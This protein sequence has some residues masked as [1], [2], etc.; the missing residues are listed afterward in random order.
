[1]ENIKC[2]IESI[3]FQN[4]NNSFSVLNVAIDGEVSTRK[5]VG[6]TFENIQPGMTIEA[7]GDW[8][9]GKYGRQFKVL[10]WQEALPTSLEGMEKYLGS[11]LITGV[12]PKFA[13]KII[14]R[15]GQQSFDIIENDIERLREIPGI[16][17]KCIDS[18]RDSWAKQTGI[19]DVM[20]F[21]QKLGVSSGIATRVYQAYGT[22]SITKVKTNPY[23]LVEDIT[24][25]GFKVAD[26][27]A[28]K[29]GVS[30][31]DPKRCRCG[32]LYEMKQT[33]SAGN[34]Y[35]NEGELFT[36]AVGLLE[37][38][39]KDVGLVLYDMINTKELI[40]DGNALYLP[41]YYYSE[42]G[43]ASRLKALNSQQVSS[44]KIDV[45][46]IL[47]R[48][49]I[50]Y[51]K[52]QEKAIN[53]AIHNNVM[54]MTGGP[55]TGKSVTT[56]GITS[57]FKALGMKILLAAP[58]GR[59]A[60]RLSQVTGMEAKTIHR[61]LEIG[62]D[63]HFTRNENNLL[64]GD[65]LIIDEASMVDILL[66]HSLLKAVPNKMRL[67]LVGDIDQ[68]PSVGAGTVLQDIIESGQFPV[69]RLTNIFR[70]AQG[71]S[72]ITNAY[73]VN[74]GKMPNLTN[75]NSSDFLFY[76]YSTDLCAMNKV[77]DLVSK[78]IPQTTEFSS[79]KIQV[80]SPMRGGKVGVKNLNLELQ[81]A[82]NPVGDSICAGG[83]QYRK[84]DRVMQIKN[85]YDT[86]VF[87]GDIG[88]VESVDLEN[89]SLKVSFDGR[90][91]D[92]DDLDELTLAYATTI[93][94]SQ[95]SEYPVVVVPLMDY[96][97][98][99]LQ[100]KLLYTAITRAKDLCVVVGSRWAFSKAVNNTTVEPR[101]SKLKDKLM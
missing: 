50:D 54:V 42:K 78:Q 65:V 68:L 26:E 62:T 61:L 67:I 24:G 64:E 27:I 70:Q 93:H 94:K 96:H 44:G 63:G 69:V 77:I 39:D 89:H 60:K 22:D 58:T 101:N 43:I 57:V 48:G 35:A 52:D 72:I 59:A 76:D 100:R 66:M 95:G 47:A 15:F 33:V 38:N 80:L 84:G 55:G 12:G 28:M 88:V 3:L 41:T 46:K 90:I 73:L 81:K 29:M 53:T 6:S 51:D 20:L 19:R 18:I 9:D 56:F 21:L 71:S 4:E 79:S 98:I 83:Y 36:K 45:D 87:N 16:G 34:V 99:M 7:F 2:I 5:I 75:N 14:E 86:D 37:T 91:V 74:Q 97:S 17:A 40:E 25:I 49:N 23:C 30:K 13:K 32:I 82:L 31:N 10:S 1:M 92:Y 11:G 85:N 8:E